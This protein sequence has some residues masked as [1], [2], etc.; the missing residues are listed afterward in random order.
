MPL[1]SHVQRKRNS[2]FDKAYRILL[3]TRR[4]L[5]VRLQEASL[6]MWEIETFTN[7]FMM[8]T[9]LVNETPKV[10][11]FSTWSFQEKCDRRTER[12]KDS[13]RRMCT[14][15]WS[16]SSR[17]DDQNKEETVCPESEPSN[18]AVVDK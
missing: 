8:G 4:V 3:R 2:N 15:T 11:S 13:R 18:Q 1:K 12:R 16:S 17:L 9:A 6:D 14:T 10:K 5:V 7:E